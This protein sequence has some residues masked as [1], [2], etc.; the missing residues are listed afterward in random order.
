MTFE[1]AKK[2]IDY[3]M[4]VNLQAV[5]YNPNISLSIGF[6]G[7]EP[8]LNWSLIKKVVEYIH[9]QYTSIFGNIFFAITT[10]GYLLSEE[11][12]KYM[13]ENNFSI[14]VSI[15]G[16][17]ETHDRNRVTINQ[18]P[19]FDV[20]FKNMLLLEEVYENMLR[21]NKKTVP[22]GILITHDNNADFEQ[23]ENFFSENPNIDGKIQRV[24]RV[25]GIN[26]DYFN[27]QNDP[28]ILQKR[29]QFLKKLVDKFK[30]QSYMNAAT[31]F[32]KVILKNLILDPM[33]LLNYSKNELRG[34]CLPGLHKLA[35]D[36]DGIFHMCE[37]INPSYSVGN[38]EIGL[39]TNKQAEYMN[40]FFSLLNSKCEKCNLQNI[41]NLCYVITESNGKGFKLDDDYCIN[42]RKGIINSL[43]TYYSILEENPQLFSELRE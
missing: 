22:Y 1:V 38:T 39:D 33:M 32:S 20:V 35:V 6:Y 9:D 37:K 8:L 24:T 28:S 14:S 15:D 3:Y 25:S 7:G 34:T 41:C 21:E 29:Q 31:N 19:T 4:D 26:T 42:Y 43:A 2:A 27:T 40:N 10:N 16:D 17:K 30:A 12:I 11:K 13:L 18:T 23:L 5:K 36:S